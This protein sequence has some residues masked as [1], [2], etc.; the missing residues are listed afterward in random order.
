MKKYLI[1]FI[2][3]AIIVSGFIYSYYGYKI[4]YNETIKTNRYYESFYQKES[5][6]TD[7]ATLI[8]KAQDNNETYKVEKDSSGNYQS[9]GKNSIII[10]LKF[11]DSDDIFRAEKVTKLGMN[12]FIK[13]YAAMTFKCTKKEYHKSTGFIKYLLLEQI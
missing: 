3:V 10:E 11:K 7:I 13:N 12:Q 5:L 2:L 8:N 1:L 9:D 4:N 6:G